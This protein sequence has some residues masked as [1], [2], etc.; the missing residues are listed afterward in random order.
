MKQTEY[1]PSRILVA[2]DLSDA[3]LHALRTAAALAETYRSEVTLVSVFDPAPYA[4]PTL[5]PGPDEIDEATI[6]SMQ[7]AA[8]R[9]LEATAQEHFGK[10][11]QHVE[12]RAVPSESTAQAIIDIAESDRINLIVVGTH[13]RRGVR[14]VLLGSVAEK[15]ARLAPCPVLIAR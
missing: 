12:V 10:R 1:A 4:T 11:M 8:R 3:S 7:E 13:G 6:R 15:V 2:T 14:R 5:F 9:A